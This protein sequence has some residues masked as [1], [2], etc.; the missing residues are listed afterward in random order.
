MTTQTGIYVRISQDHEGEALG[1]GRQEADCRELCT[2][3]GWEVA[4]VYQDNDVTASG[5]KLRPSW[6]RLLDNIAA[7]RLNAVVAYSSSR[8]YRH[9]RDLQAFIEA[10]ESRGVAVATVVSGELDL[11]T[12]DGRMIARLLAAADQREWEAT[13]E[14]WKRQKRQAVMDE[15]Y[16]GGE[17][18]P[19]GYRRVDGKLEV[20][21]EE[22]AVL[23]DGIARLA[24]GEGALRIC[25]EWNAAGLR[26]S[27]DGR[28]VPRSL[29]R[30]LTSDHITGKRGYPRVLS[31][32]EVALARSVLGNTKRQTG[33]PSGVAAP[34]TGGLLV[35]G[36]CGIKMSSASGSY[37]CAASHGGCGSISIR[38]GPLERWL[39]VESVRRWLE[40][41][42]RKKAEPATEPVDTAPLMAELARLDAREEEVGAAMADGTLTV[43]SAAEATKRIKARRAEL[44]EELARSLPAP[45]KDSLV[46][47]LADIF[48]PDEMDE[49]GLLSPPFVTAGILRDEP[50][51][52]FRERW[53]TGDA[54]AVAQVRDI[55]LEVLDHAVINRREHRSKS[56]D[57]ARVSI[58]WQ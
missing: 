19:F 45:A 27:R 34:L 44:T 20:D 6:V 17:S 43:R 15:K 39:L 25:R 1:V 4:E 26:T 23:L 48:T 32:T 38:R 36:N 2:R 41:G 57:P 28:W 46:A 58:V 47:K 13:S 22:K 49:L 55:F 56:F 14:R 37:R 50:W 51:R 7:G 35:C 30:V 42:E 52:A 40:V 8:L 29:V 54:E 9:A 21:P 11:T 53:E 31:D 10:V 18:E 5:K 33:R 3:R 24:R 16:T 12:A